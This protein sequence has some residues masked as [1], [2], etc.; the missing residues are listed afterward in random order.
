VKP[1]KRGEQGE[2]VPF[3][4]VFVV[5]V[6]AFLALAVDGGYLLA[7]RRRAIDEADAAARA[8]AQALA[9]PAYRSSGVVEVDPEAAEEAAQGFLGATGHGGRVE[10]VDDRVMVTVSF[11]QPMALLRVVGVDE[12]SV[13]GRGEAQA[14]RGVESQ[15]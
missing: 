10:V 13:S 1:D 6:L 7:A 12:M 9:V 15:E 5:A 2:F 11:A 3:V 8:G 14:V 4:A